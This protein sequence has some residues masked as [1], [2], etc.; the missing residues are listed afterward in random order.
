MPETRINN[1]GVETVHENHVG[2]PLKR[3][4]WSAVFAGV[5]AALIIHIL[6]G[7]LGTAIGATTIDPQQ[8]QNPLQHLGTGALIWTG[9]S[10]LIAMAVGSYVAGRLAQREGAMHGLLMFGVS[11]ILT[12]WLAITLATGIIGGAFNILGAGVNAVGSGISAAAP[13]LTNMAKEKLQESNINLDDLK[14]ELQTTLRQTG[15]SEL[16]PENL[17]KDVNN[18]ANNAQN[19]AEQTAQNPQNADNDL[20]NW[21]KGVMN[22]HSDTLQAADRDALKNIIKARTGKSD[23][24]VEQIVTKTEESYKKAVQQYQQLKQQAEQKAREVAEQ[25]AAATAKASWFTFFMLVIE[26]VLAALM[27]RVGRKTQPRQVLSHERR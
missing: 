27:G 17:Q 10:M 5:I 15:K 2:L 6:L 25:A 8:E 21:L 20:A 26:A 12:L 22:R 11:T 13:S 24:E 14:N 23:Q 7:I 16:Q 3:I 19:Q 4:S 1:G 18:E 9:V